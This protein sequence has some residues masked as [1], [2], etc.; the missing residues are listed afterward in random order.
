LPTFSR[1]PSL[2]G[3]HKNLARALGFDGS[4][5]GIPMF[6]V[7]YDFDMYYA[8]V[9]ANLLSNAECIW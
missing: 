4:T 8:V 9:E 7:A 3:G 2:R 1:P 5:P 6:F